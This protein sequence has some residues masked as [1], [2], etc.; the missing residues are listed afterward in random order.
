MSF[1][2]RLGPR[3][4]AILW[5]ACAGASLAFTAPERGRVRA[6][7]CLSGTLADEFTADRMG[8]AREWIIQIP[9]LAPGRT[10]ENVVA[11]DGLV[12]AGTSDGLVH[13]IQAT[14]SQAAPGTGAPLPG[15]LLWSRSVG[16]AGGHFEQAG[17]GAELVAVC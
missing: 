17:I 15:T 10:L 13:A 6:G 12:V 8:L 11:G 2:T 4:C 5:T 7:D 9:S 1:S 14:P 16:R 3:A